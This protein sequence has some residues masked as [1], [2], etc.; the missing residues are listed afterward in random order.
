MN[1]ALCQFDNSVLT[2]FKKSEFSDYHTCWLAPEKPSPGA[3]PPE[4]AAP[5]LVLDQMAVKKT[6]QTS[7]TQFH[8][9]TPDDVSHFLGYIWKGSKLLEF[10]VWQ[11]MVEAKDTKNLRSRGIRHNF[12]NFR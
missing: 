10:R 6:G 11:K 1:Q 9:L 2:V 4:A 12:S 7:L 8:F 5:G 3:L